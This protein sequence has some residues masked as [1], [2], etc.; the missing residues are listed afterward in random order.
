MALVLDTLGQDRVMSDKQRDI[1]R[2]WARGICDSWENS[3][4]N[5]LQ[6]S[7]L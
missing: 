7:T 6:D 1:A 5:L 2:K 4:E 3:E